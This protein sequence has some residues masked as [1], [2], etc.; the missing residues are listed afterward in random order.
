VVASAIIEALGALDLAFPDVDKEK[1][2]ELAEI[3]N[4]L[5]EGKD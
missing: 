5:L 2:K 3:R 1:K 4:A